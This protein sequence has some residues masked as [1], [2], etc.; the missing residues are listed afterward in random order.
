M[1][2]DAS[3]D[4]PGPA[5][6]GERATIPLFP[7]GLVLLPGMLLPLNIFEPRYRTLVQDLL[8]SPAQ[9]LPAFGVVAIRQGHEVGADSVSSLYEIGTIA[10]V[11]RIESL[12]DGRFNLMSFGSHRFEVHDLDHSRPYLQASVSMIDDPDEPADAGHPEV[13]ELVA[14]FRTY[15]ETLT[16]IRG[17][18]LSVP[19]LPDATNMLSW[20]IAGTIVVDLPVRQRLLEILRT[21]ERLAAEV[22]LL[23]S[24]TNL[25]KK[26]AAAPAPYLVRAPQHPN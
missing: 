12:P 14:A 3:S 24:E 2:P 16:A 25:L 1:P 9:S 19:T 17:D 4:G 10:T 23:R 7:L 13:P 11:T 18:E 5:A 20:L 21:P 6:R 8:A 22:A 26:M 15:L